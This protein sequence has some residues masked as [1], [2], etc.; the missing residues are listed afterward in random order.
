MKKETSTNLTRKCQ[1][2]KVILFSNGKPD[3]LAIDIYWDFFRSWYANPKLKT[4][5]VRISYRKLASFYNTTKQTIRL[6]IVKLEQLGLVSRSFETKSYYG[7]KVY[8]LLVIYLWKKTPHFYNKHGIHRSEATTP[9]PQTNYKYIS[10]KYNISYPVKSQLNKCVESKGGIIIEHDT[11]QLSSFS[12]EKGRSIDKSNSNKH[13]RNQPLR[14]DD[15]KA[16]IM[17]RQTEESPKAK[18]KT[19]KDFYPLVAKDY[20]SIKLNCGREFSLNAMNE[21]LLDISR[22]LT[23]PKFYS[24]KGFISYMSKVYRYEM[25]DASRISRVDFRIR[26]NYRF[27]RFTTSPKEKYLTEIENNSGTESTA[28]FKRRIA[29]KL[30]ESSAYKLLIN[31]KR[32]E[33]KGGGA[34][35]YLEDTIRLSKNDR[36]IIDEEIWA[37][38]DTDHR[39]RKQLEIIIYKKETTSASR[40]PLPSETASIKLDSSIDIWNSMRNRMVD[41]QG[42]KGIHIDRH[43]IS[44]LSAE[45]DQKRKQIKLTAQ[46]EMVK[47]YV[48]DKYYDILLNVINQ[49]GFELTN[50]C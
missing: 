39:Y 22:R 41:L 45:I 13:K 20:D 32:I 29:S 36:R 44:R 38:M 23:K 6:K 5:G 10:T 47:D 9:K 42:E 26:N 21:I 43:W 24:K 3:Y 7:Y 18:V 4:Q 40:V 30:K 25:R 31:F 1:L 28:R 16:T 37:A 33:I 46:N 48:A 27:N 19:L 2:F 34:K 12:K 17:K 8:N 35:L 50:Y 49:S 15:S 11:E 14:K